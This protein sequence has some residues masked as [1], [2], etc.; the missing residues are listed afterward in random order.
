MSGVSEKGEGGLRYGNKCLPST[1]WQD[2]SLTR[3]TG[4]K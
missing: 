3:F 4:K 1:K 2:I